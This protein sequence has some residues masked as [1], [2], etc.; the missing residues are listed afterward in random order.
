MVPVLSITTIEVECD[1]SSADI[2]LINK[3]CEAPVPVPTTKAVG[4]ELG[5]GGQP[6]DAGFGAPRGPGGRDHHE[7]VRRVGP[8]RRLS[9]SAVGYRGTGIGVRAGEPGVVTAQEPQAGG[10]SLGRVDRDGE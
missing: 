5:A 2:P 7:G 4:V 3:P 9:G 1:F 10:L 6:H 8:A